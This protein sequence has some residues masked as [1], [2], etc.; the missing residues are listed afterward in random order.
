[1]LQPL[2]IRARGRYEAAM[3][4]RHIYHAGN[5]ADVV[6]H[7]ALVL[8]L[9]HLKRK[10]TA[11][12]VLDTHAGIGRYDLASDQA[13]KTGE[14][15]TG[16]AKIMAHEAGLGALAGIEPYLNIVRQMNNGANSGTLRHYPGS[17]RIARA[18]LRP[19]DRLALVELHPEDAR[20]LQAEFA[21]DAQVAIHHQDAYVALKA[22]LPPPERRGMVLIDPPFEVKDE[23]Q[24]ILRGLAQA[25]KRW[26][27]GVY[28][29]WYP[30][31]DPAPIANFHR[32]LAALCGGKAIIAEFMIRPAHDC[33]KLNGAGL[34]IVNP[35]WQLQENL[36][37]LLPQLGPI[38]AAEQGYA[39]V[40]ALTAK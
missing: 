13:G 26:P 17:P 32:D 29:I 27:T 2:F 30:I 16:I 8:I 38:L 25:W 19:Q 18:L 11:F 20:A 1:M 5:F 3:N 7:I 9:E 21:G 39:R 15:Q 24:R 31:K 37:A 33:T 28:A 23:F 34:A 36:A 14:F 40:E 35:P 6:K 22:L 4:Y 12:V 10:E